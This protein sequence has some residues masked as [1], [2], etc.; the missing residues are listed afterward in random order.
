MA[1]PESD[2]SEDS[3]SD[4]TGDCEEGDDGCFLQA[5]PR[6]MTWQTRLLRVSGVAP[7]SAEPLADEPATEADRGCH[8]IP[9]R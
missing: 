6:F 8:V 1:G 4:S 7:T 3:A 2:F 5:A 9:P